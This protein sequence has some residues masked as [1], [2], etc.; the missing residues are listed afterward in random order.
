MKQP[1]YA[2]YEQEKANLQKLNL[3]PEQYTRAIV[4]LARKLG[5]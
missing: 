4:K 5:V 3:T 2:R 1:D